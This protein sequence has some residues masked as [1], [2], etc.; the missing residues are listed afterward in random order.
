MTPVID[1]F[2]AN[3]DAAAA[4]LAPWR[5]F[6]D[7]GEI[8]RAARFRFERDRNRYIVR[9]GILRLLLADRLACA[10]A[11]LRFAANAYGKPSLV[12]GGAEFN[13]SHSHGIALI[14]FSR[15]VAL[16]CDI[17]LQ[18]ARFLAENI[19]E[20]LLSPAELHELR[21]RAPADQVVAFFDGWTRK[22]AYIKARGLG[23]SL[24]LDSFDVSLAPGAR[25]ELHRGCAGWSARSV[26]P[27]QGFSAA[28]VAE[29]ADWQ[30]AAHPLDPAS[31]FAET[32]AACA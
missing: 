12:G 7:E 16:G 3:L 14:A 27:A 8:A 32:A 1:V 5:A 29:G 21:A 28:I 24:P 13:L 2:W 25:P 10:P 17:E 15:D 6:L 20:R 19:P 18:D 23:L 9:H 22:E 31:L 30:I 11:A 4:T 26:T